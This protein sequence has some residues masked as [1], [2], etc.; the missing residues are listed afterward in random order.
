MTISF[1]R[2]SRANYAREPSLRS[3]HAAPVSV[4]ELA[5]SLRGLHFETWP[6][7]FR[8][9]RLVEAE[10]NDK[11]FRSCVRCGSLLSFPDRWSIPSSAL[12]GSPDSYRQHSL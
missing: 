6:K 12:L 3:Q 5:S 10:H 7:R 1:V 2:H 9:E 4:P 8:P 11:S